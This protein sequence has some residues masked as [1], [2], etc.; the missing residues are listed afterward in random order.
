[1]KIPDIDFL[2]F[3]SFFFIII[4]PAANNTQLN[5]HLVI[6][7]WL[8]RKIWCWTVEKLGRS[9]FLELDAKR[10]RPSGN[11]PSLKGDGQMVSRKLSDQKLHYGLFVS[12]D[13][14]KYLISIILAVKEGC[15]SYYEKKGLW[16][17]LLWSIVIVHE[18]ALCRHQQNGGYILIQKT[19]LCFH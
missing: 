7:G 15:C 11:F 5:N 9:S 6:S 17:Q 14:L 12:V 8:Y 16:N 10:R 2:S 4:I 19:E 3:S 13:I 1:M 18:S